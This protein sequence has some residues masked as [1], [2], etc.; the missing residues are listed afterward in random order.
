MT[1][2]PKA[3][4]GD[5]APSWLKAA[6]GYYGAAFEA[7]KKTDLAEAM[8]DWSEMDSDE[9]GFVLAHLQ[10]LNLLAQRD[11]H[12]LLLELRASVE[13][14]GDEVIEAVELAGGEPDE[15][16]LEADDYEGEPEQEPVIL[17]EE[18]VAAPV[19]TL[20]AVPNEPEPEDDDD[21]EAD[22]EPAPEPA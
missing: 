3:R 10:Y 7:K 13:V 14:I 22:H 17:D 11:I 2:F 15:E 4:R 21:P 20:V 6:R 16:L 18:P 9:R 1:T 5:H 19:P 12:R 8:A